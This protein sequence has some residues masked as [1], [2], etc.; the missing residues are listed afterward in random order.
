M[1][2][3]AK[4]QD[5]MTKYLLNRVRELERECLKGAQKAKERG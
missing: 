4:N 5:E 1:G 2:E 3:K